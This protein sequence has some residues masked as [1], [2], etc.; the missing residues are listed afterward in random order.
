M[1]A[2]TPTDPRPTGA[3]RQQRSGTRLTREQAARALGADMGALD[4]RLRASAASSRDRALSGSG[5]RL[6]Q[7]AALAYALTS[8]RTAEGARSLAHCLGPV[9]RIRD[10]PGE[11][12]ADHCQGRLA[13]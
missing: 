10:L 7:A 2:P 6:D 13:W 9:L 3:R 8:P 11:N 4:A 1:Q 12:V 5:L